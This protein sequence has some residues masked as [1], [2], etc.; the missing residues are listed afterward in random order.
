MFA[1]PF[2]AGTPSA[3]AGSYHTMPPIPRRTAHRH[4][5]ASA[6]IWRALRAQFEVMRNALMVTTNLYHQSDGL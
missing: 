5:A 4:R 6:T 2:V 1:S 3:R